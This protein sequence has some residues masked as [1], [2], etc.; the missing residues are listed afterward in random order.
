VTYLLR[1]ILVAR[2]EY[3]I[4][5]WLDTTGHHTLE[6]AWHACDD[7]TW[8]I[9]LARG[10]APNELLA[11]AA[12]DYADASGNVDA[13]RDTSR[14]EENAEAGHMYGVAFFCESAAFNAWRAD[15]T[16]DLCAILR[17]RVPVEV[18]EA[19]LIEWCKA[20][21]PQAL[22][23]VPPQHGMPILVLHDISGSGVDLPTGEHPPVFIPAGKVRT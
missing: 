12:R 10:N 7:A 2:H 11:Q 14:A 9:T 13:E 18:V 5:Y 22:V 6:E 16:I 17:A 15:K 20:N 1:P 3:P 23:E 4:L 8:L 19:G 21:A